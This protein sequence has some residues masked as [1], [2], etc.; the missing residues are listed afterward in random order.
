[1]G[2]PGN[3][4]LPFYTTDRTTMAN[5]IN[6]II[7]ILKKENNPL[8]FLLSRILVFIKLNEFFLVTRT[9]YKPRLFNTSISQRLWVDNDSRIDDEVFLRSY[10]Q[11]GDFF[12]DVG[13]NIGNVSLTAA[14][15]LS[16]NSQQPS[17]I[18]FEP[19]KKV[20]T[21]LC[22]NIE[23]NKFTHTIRTHNIALGEA[24]GFV[25]L[26]DEKND[27]LKRVVFDTRNQS[28]RLD[29][30]DALLGSQK[31]DLLKIDVEGFELSVLKGSSGLLPMT[32]AIYFEY[33]E[34]FTH[35]YKY[36][37]SDIFDFLS[38]YHYEFYCPDVHEMK[39]TKV[40]RGFQAEGTHNILAF[41]PAMRAK[42]LTGYLFID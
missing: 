23:L 42:K 15:I 21:F 8:R 5:K 18:A 2:W 22:K 14:T 28:I 39:L 12:V 27:G 35:R 16:S 33:N 32:D 6:H 9:G 20:Y 24:S 7:H 11:R 26:T 36:S 37:F 41:K 38:Q 25:N 30:L 19:N 17:V 1:M 40:T 34:K 31:I 13:A 4:W 3:V 10:L 29:R